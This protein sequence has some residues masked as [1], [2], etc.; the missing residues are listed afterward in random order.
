MKCHP[1]K[2]PDDPT[3]EETF[4]KVSQAYQVLS[5]PALKA[6]YDQHGKEAT[7]GDGANMDPKEFFARMFGGGK[8][9]VRILLVQLA[10]LNLRN[11]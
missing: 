4:K 10:D 2:H 6:K 3:A 5:D 7:Q 11:L 8:F 1:D 9:D